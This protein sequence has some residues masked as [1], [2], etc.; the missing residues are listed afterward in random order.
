MLFDRA[1]TLQSLHGI[2]ES[3]IKVKQSLKSSYIELSVL[4]FIVYFVLLHLWI[5]LL[6]VDTE[7]F[8]KGGQ[9]P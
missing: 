7:T 4:L 6:L 3:D 9:P 8:L 1:Q 2:E 5:Q